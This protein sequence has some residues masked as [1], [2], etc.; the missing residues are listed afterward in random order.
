MGTGARSRPRAKY[1]S[2]RAPSQRSSK[3]HCQELDR[4]GFI[5]WYDNRMEKLTKDGMTDGV[6]CSAFVLL[7]LSADVLT[8]PF[9][10]HELSEAM[11]ARKHV[12]FLGL[13]LRELNAKADAAAGDALVLQWNLTLPARLGQTVVDE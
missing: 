6:K 9:V 2:P 8:R 1:L 13:E 11:K 7:F 4:R 3:H 10:L 12:Y 5:C